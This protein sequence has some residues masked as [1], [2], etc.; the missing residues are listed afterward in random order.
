[1]NVPDYYSVLGM[2]PGASQDELKKRYRTLIAKYHPDRNSDAGAEE[3]SKM[4]N[5]AYSILADPDKRSRYDR[6]L[7]YPVY[8]NAYEG[9]GHRAYGNSGNK[10]NS[11][12]RSN[13][14]SYSGEN[15]TY[16]SYTSR[17]HY[18]QESTENMG[19]SRILLRSIL[20]TIS[21][22]V[23]LWLVLHFFVFFV[24]LIFMM[25][26]LYL[27]WVVMGQIVGFFFYRR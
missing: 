9:Y 17:T 21:L 10:D 3:Q 27:I 4:I 2:P 6:S 22:L 14:R 25:M 7:Q 5:E 13:F 20:K 8:A 1:M 18:S 16:R 26:L 23:V 15:Y 11:D 12:R 19:I 24:F